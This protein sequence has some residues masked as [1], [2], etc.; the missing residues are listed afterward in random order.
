MITFES[1]AIKLCHSTSYVLVLNMD[2]TYNSFVIPNPSLFK[3]KEYPCT[4]F[5]SPFIALSIFI[6]VYYSYDYVH[7]LL[8]G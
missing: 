8:M 5:T 2:P 7:I 6:K 1:L 3:T 4:S